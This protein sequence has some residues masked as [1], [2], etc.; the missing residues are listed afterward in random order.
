MVAMEYT[1]DATL[2]QEEQ[3]S[4]LDRTTEKLNLSHQVLSTDIPK[5]T[6]LH[7]SSMGTLK[8]ENIYHSDL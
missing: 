5:P 7:K 8:E 1:R 3:E 4:D 6:V 2:A